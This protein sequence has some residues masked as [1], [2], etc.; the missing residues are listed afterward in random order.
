MDQFSDKY[1]L[2]VQQ[3]F[4]GKVTGFTLPR[5]ACFDDKHELTESDIVHAEYHASMAGKSGSFQ[6]GYYDIN[7]WE[8]Y[9]PC[10]GP[11]DSEHHVL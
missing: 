6:V 10:Q 2:Q 4:G 1:Y 3:T 8:F 7:L 11:V 5:L 9:D